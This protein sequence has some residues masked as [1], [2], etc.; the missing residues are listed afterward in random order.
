[1]QPCL[2]PFPAAAVQQEAVGGE[3]QDFEEDEQVEQVTGEEGAVEAE[4][5]QLEQHVEVAALGI[6]AAYRVQQR[7]HRQKGR[8]QQHPRRQPVDHQHDAVGRGP[9]AELVDQLGAVAGRLHQR[10]CQRNQRQ[11]GDEADAALQAVLAQH[12]Q[13]DAGD[14]RQHHRQD[15]QMIKPVHACRPSSWCRPS[16]WSLPSSARAFSASTMTKAVMPKLMT[17]AVSTSA[18]GS[19]SV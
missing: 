11:R 6:A 13:H 3:Q 5:L 15:G 8:R 18:C 19:G 17:M 2:D 14:E 4:Q 9:V 7:K 16:T 10:N 12:Q 1:M